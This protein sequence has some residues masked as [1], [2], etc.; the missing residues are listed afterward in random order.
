M[1]KRARPQRCNFSW[2]MNMRRRWIYA[3]GVAAVAI[4]ASIWW[5]FAHRGA[6]ESTADVTPSVQLAAVRFG[7]FTVVLDES[8]FIGAPAGSSTQLA[9]ASS[10]VLRT[11]YVH[12]GDRVAAGQSLAALDVQPLALAA[13]GA[14]A[15]SRAADAAAVAAAVD[16]YSTRLIVDSNAVARQERLYNAGVVAFKD[17]EDAR[18]TLAADRADARGADAQSAAARALAASAADKAALAKNDLARATLRSPSDGVVT[19][20]LH[21]AGEPVD[22]SMPVVVVG[23]ADQHEATLRVPSTDA[24]QMAAGD[25]VDLVVSGS[26]QHAM[27]RVAAVIAAVDPATQTA[28]VIVTG[29]PGDAVAGAAVRA[30]IAVAHVRGLLVPQSAIVADPQ[31]GDN[32]V[33]ARQRQKD[34][35]FKFAQIAVSVQHE[36]GSTALIAAGLRPGERVAAQGAFEL[37]APSGGGD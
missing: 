21:R 14:E 24:S 28:T 25:T 20:I 32:V 7:D 6:P 35:S 9:F 30:R 33:F 2:E 29:V 23:P 15:D 16:R 1:R 11:L 10:G 3:S 37:L 12:V 17:V 13:R 31:N 26:P 4:I 19:A 36:D 5:T 18:A 22:Q 27:G 34:G 8:G